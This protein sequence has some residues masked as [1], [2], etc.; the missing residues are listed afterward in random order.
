MHELN[1]RGKKLF[2]KPLTLHFYFLPSQHAGH[3][4]PISERAELTQWALYINHYTE[5]HLHS[6]I[7]T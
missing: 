4:S 5:V 2:T 6:R 3:S 1:Y 7:S